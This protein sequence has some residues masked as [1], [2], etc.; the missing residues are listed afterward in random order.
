MKMKMPKIE[1]TI[2][3]IYILAKQNVTSEKQTNTKHHSLNIHKI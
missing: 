3:E 1:D 2:E